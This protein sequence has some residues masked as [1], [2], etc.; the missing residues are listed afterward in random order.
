MK[1]NLT[2]VIFLFLIINNIKEGASKMLDIPPTFS[3]VTGEQ[4]DIFVSNANFSSHIVMT[5]GTCARI[6]INFPSGNSCIALFLNSSKGEKII[7]KIFQEPH[8]FS[9]N[10]YNG[11]SLG[12]ESNSSQLLLKEYG[13]DSVRVIR[14]GIVAEEKNRRIFAKY[15][16]VPSN[17]VKPEVN[18]E[19]Q[20]KTLTLTRTTLDEKHHY[21][22]KIN[23]LNGKVITK[24]GKT[25]KFITES[26]APLKFQLKAAIDFPPL[27]PLSVEEIITPSA[28]QFIQELL[29]KGKK[30]EYQKSIQ[31][32][33]NLSALTYKD[34]FIAGSWRFMTYFGRDT[35]L[36]ILMLKNILTPRAFEIAIQSVLDRLSPDGEVAHEEDIGEQAT[37]RR[38]REFNKLFGKGLTREAQSILTTTPLDKPIYDYKMIDDD[39]ML[40]ILATSYI[41]DKTKKRN[42]W[43]YNN[44]GEKNITKLLKN[45]NYIL[46]Q[47]LPLVESGKKG[48]KLIPYLIHLKEGELAGDWRDSNTGLGGGIYP[49]SVNI[50]LVNNSLKAISIFIKSGLYTKEELK[51]ISKQN[52]L[53]YLNKILKEESLLEKFSLSWGQ[54]RTLYKVTLTPT[55]IRNKLSLYI[56]HHPLPPKEKEALLSTPLQEGGYTVKKFIENNEIPPLLKDGISFYALSLTKDGEPVKVIN[57]DFCFTL[58]LGEPKP[59]EIKEILKIINLPYPVGLYSS[60][61]IFTANPIYSDNHKH[62]H[63]L[64]RRAYHGTVVWGWQMAMLEKG[65]IKQLNKYSTSKKEK[66]LVKQLKSTLSKIFE[67]EKNIGTLTSAEL[68]SYRIKDGRFYPSPYGQDK[69]EVTESNAFQLWSSIYP[70]VIMDAKIIYKNN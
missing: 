2:F 35:I 50:D 63:T 44:G 46:K 68:W 64:D 13:L 9:A 60:A 37:R 3:L 56:S 59:E 38:V 36:G 30:D 57:S 7:L 32:L 20:S 5:N 47:T 40:P 17:W 48:K 22:L 65:L 31:A 27:T 70:A 51:S 54:V 28:K 39:F 15:N 1:V 8:I 69:G 4:E 11:V 41:K 62:W 12:I 34:K 58:F 6:L 16:K 14:D 49:G 19:N 55:E 67:L 29:V 26:K 52:K 25:F 24:G 23:L 43:E 33:R 61:G 21:L 66:E 18:I 45:W 42:F 10:S 53:E